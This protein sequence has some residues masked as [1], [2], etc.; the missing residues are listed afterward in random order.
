MERHYTVDEIA[1]SLAVSSATVR[2]MFRDEPGVLRLSVEPKPGRRP[3]LTI[4]VPESVLSRVLL[5]AQ[6]A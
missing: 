6:G 3:Y 4:R 1:A 5:R 2:R